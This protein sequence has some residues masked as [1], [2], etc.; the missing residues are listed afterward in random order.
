MYIYRKVKTCV[1]LINKAEI[2]NFLGINFFNLFF[3]GHQYIPNEE[4]CMFTTY[5]HIYQQQF[6]SQLLE[7]PSIFKGLN[8]Q[9]IIPREL[10]LYMMYSVGS[11]RWKKFYIIHSNEIIEMLFLCLWLKNINL[12][13]KWIRK[14]FEKHDLKKHKKLFLLLKYLL[15]SFIWNHNL[16]FKLKGVRLILRGKF[17]K[18]GSVR[19]SRKYIKRGKCSYT[20]KN[21]ALVNQTKTIRTST[22][23]FAIKLEIFFKKWCLL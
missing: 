9:D 18:A 1:L 2:N 22:G 7:T 11:I 23:V 20:S 15:G 17:A 4:P 8:M 19:K 16:L 21:I 5:Q 6:I 14:Y 3:S 13:I 10:L 12:F